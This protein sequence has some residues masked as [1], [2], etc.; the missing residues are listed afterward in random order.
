MVASV[1][2]C[3]KL[4][5]GTEVNIRHIVIE[6]TSQWPI[7]RNVTTKYDIIHTNGNYPKLSNRTKTALQ[8]IDMHSYVL[9]YIFLDRTNSNCS[10]FD[11]KL[12]CA[13]VIIKEST[14]VLPWSELRNIIYKVHKHF[15]GQASQVTLKFY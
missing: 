6:G 11:A 14:S 12:L 8:N 3:A 15:F 2:I 7:G 4:N 10:N 9:S 1:M 5:N 13:T